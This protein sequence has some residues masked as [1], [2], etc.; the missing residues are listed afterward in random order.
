LHNPLAGQRR[1]S[2]SSVRRE[3]AIAT[4]LD[5]TDSAVMDQPSEPKKASPRKSKIAMTQIQET[6][7]DGVSAGKRNVE[8]IGN[9]QDVLT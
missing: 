9:L 3:A 1:R 5:Q 6:S 4:R 8:I 2:N 7:R